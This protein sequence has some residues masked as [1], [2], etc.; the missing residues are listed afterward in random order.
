MPASSI[1]VS[2]ASPTALSPADSVPAHD[3][4]TVQSKSL[5]EPRLINVHTPPKYRASH[6][7]NA[8]KFPVLYMPDGGLDEDSPHVAHAVDSLI[9]SGAIRPVI[10]VG[11]PN[12]QRRRDLTGPTRVASDSAIAPHVGG[13][14]AFRRFLG[15]ELTPEIDR[16][17]RTTPERGIIGESL[18]R[19][20]IVEAFLEEP[21]LFSHYIAF[22]PSVWWNAGALVDSASQRIAAFDA[23]PRTLY[24]ATSREPSTSVGTSKIVEMLRTSPPPRLRWTY[25]PRTDRTHGN[26]FLTLEARALV[27]AFH[28]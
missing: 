20:F 25:D 12:T 28:D 26:I 27:D 1:A 5:S 7:S 21:K 13:S 8:R 10:V 19:L 17:Y 11:V 23:A 2:S 9:A 22:D 15:E 3:S 24:V 4:F 16:R 18:A 6:G 14:A